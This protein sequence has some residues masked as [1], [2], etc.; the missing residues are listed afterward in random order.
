MPAQRESQRTVT[1]TA[2]RPK[3]SVIAW[4]V[5]LSLLACVGAIVL[6]SLLGAA[7]ANALAS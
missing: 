6:G 7:I 2:R 1:K 5:T 3:L 4:Y